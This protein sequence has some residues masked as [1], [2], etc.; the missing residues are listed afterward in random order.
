MDAKLDPSW[1][2]GV[3]ILKVFGQKMLTVKEVTLRN[4][5]LRHL[6]L[7]QNNYSFEAKR[8]ETVR[9]CSTQWEMRVYFSVGY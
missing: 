2:K 9:A 3:L 8:N 7:S 4:E 5:G 6:H 1:E